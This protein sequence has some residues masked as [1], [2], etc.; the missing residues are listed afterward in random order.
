MNL[1][2]SSSSTTSATS[3]FQECL[4]SL[5]SQTSPPLAALQ[6]TRIRR[7]QLPDDSLSSL[8]PS[9]LR[10]I[11]CGYL[12]VCLRVK[13]SRRHARKGQDRL[14]T[15][16]VDAKSRRGKRIRTTCPACSRVAVHPCPPL[17]E[18]S[19]PSSEI[20]PVGINAVVAAADSESTH[21]SGSSSERMQT[22]AILDIS[23]HPPAP[24][25][26]ALHSSPSPAPDPPPNKSTSHADP[27]KS[28]KR[29]KKKPGL[30]ELIARSK[31]QEKNRNQLKNEGGSGLS[32]FL[33]GL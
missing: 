32:A 19:Y 5:L 23:T 15:P 28:S 17:N 3:R 13:S 9:S 10:C 20:T 11:R 16:T 8:S 21:P 6:A 24:T 30:A 1:S 29:P 27:P 33:S 26:S 25:I 4:L 7:Q 31:A 12:G 14:R 22:K 18:S 2:S